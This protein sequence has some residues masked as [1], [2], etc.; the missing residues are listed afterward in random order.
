MK[1]IGSDRAR[2]LGYFATALGRLKSRID[3]E[4]DR[5]V[6]S[7]AKI[8]EAQVRLII[9]RLE[10]VE[11]FDD[12]YSMTF[13]AQLVLFERAIR[14]IRPDVPIAVLEEIMARQR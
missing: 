5:S 3:K 4:H 9:K 14:S 7:I 10:A 6:Y 2:K 13:H 11:G 12:P 8:T 1:N